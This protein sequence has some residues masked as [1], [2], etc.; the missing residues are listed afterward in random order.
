MKRSCSYGCEV[1]QLPQRMWCLGAGNIYRAPMHLTPGPEGQCDLEF[2]PG[3]P[4]S[5]ICLSDG[6][7]YSYKM[8]IQCCPVPPEI[9]CWLR[10]YVGI[11]TSKFIRINSFQC[12]VPVY[13]ALRCFRQAAFWTRGSNAA[14]R[15]AIALGEPSS[16][17][18]RVPAILHSAA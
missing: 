3:S 14:A 6:E 8:G 17:Y 5:Q 10:M 7:L 11:R 12:G 9:S 16:R 18:V 15:S 4:P 13:F 1:G 2:E